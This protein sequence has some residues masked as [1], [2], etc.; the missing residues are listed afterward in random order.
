MHNLGFGRTRQPALPPVAVIG[1]FD[2]FHLG[3]RQLVE[4]AADVARREGRP[5]A[6][7][8][9]H[10]RTAR[11]VLNGVDERCWALMASGASTAL[12][13]SLETSGDRSLA[14]TVVDEIVDR[15]H[16]ELVVMACLPGLDSRPRY[17][18]I[19]DEFARQR[20]R[21]VEVPRWTNPDGRIITSSLVRHALATGE[22]ARANDWLGRQFTLGGTV[23]HGSGLGRTIGFPTA[24]LDLPADRMI[25][26]NGVYAAFVDLADGTTHRSAVNIGIRPTV[27]AHGELLVEAHLLD[28]DGDLYGTRID[29]RFRRWLRDE[30]RFDS[31]DDLV[32]QMGIDV[33]QSRLVLRR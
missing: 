1:E 30:R 29:V 28:F 10:D 12:A 31:V 15:L 21:L 16:P 9:L 3:H 18:S 27:E 11:H 26:M 7:V 5:L 2:G 6:A 33:S 23:V 13:V 19:R 14:A 32:R 17:P 24:N 22:V 4:G 20:V 25:P 8:V